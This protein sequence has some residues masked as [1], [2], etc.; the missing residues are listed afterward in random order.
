MGFP[1]AGYTPAVRFIVFV[2]GKRSIAPTSRAMARQ[3]RNVSRD[4]NKKKLTKP[5]NCINI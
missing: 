2:K 5:P 1:C 3:V 4:K